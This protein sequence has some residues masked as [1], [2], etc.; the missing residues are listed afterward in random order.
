MGLPVTLV[1]QEIGTSTEGDRSLIVGFLEDNLSG[2]GRDIRIVGFEG[3]LSSSATLDELTI[4]DEEGVWF[5]LRDAELDW[6]RTALLRGRVEV[7]RITA[8]EILFERL[9]EMTDEGIDLPDPEAKPFALPELP[10][11]IDIGEIAAERVVLG[12]PVLR[13]G[14]EVT[15]SLAGSMKLADGS[16]SADL[17]ITRLDDT[18]TFDLSVSYENATEQLDLDLALSEGQGGLVTRL[19]N[20]NGAP[21]LDLDIEGTGPLD[22]FTAQIA[23]ATQGEDRLTGTVAL[24]APVDESDPDAPAPRRFSADLAGDLTPL[25][26]AEYAEF[27]GPSSTLSAQ[28]AS[29]PA[30]GFD[31]DRFTLSTQTLSLVGSAQIA[32]DGLPSAFSISGSLNGL[33]QRPVLLPFGDARS[34]VQSA[35]ILATFN[36]GESEDWAADISVEG[37][38]QD[39]LDIGRATLTGGGTIAREA[40][41]DGT[42]LLSRVNG[43]FN[44]NLTEFASDTPALQEAIGTAPAFQGDLSWREGEPLQISALSLRTDATRATLSGQLEGLDSG[45]TFSGNMSLDTP[46]LARFAG[47]SGMALEGGAVIFAEGSVSPLSGMFDLST[48]ARGQD[49]KIGIDQVDA[50]IGGESNVRLIARR[51]ETGLTVD[52]LRVSSAAVEA[53][54]STTLTSESGTVTLSARLDDLSRLGVALSGPATIDLSAE[55]QDG[56]ESWDSTLS[57][58]GPDGASADISGLLSGLE[59]VPVFD[60]TAEI[61]TPELSALSELTGMRLG[62]R[63]STRA[64][65]K[66]IPTE[67]QFDLSLTAEG[68]NLRTGIAQVD[69]VISGTSRVALSAARGADGLLQIRSAD[70]RTPAL[71]A[72]A[73]GS[74]G[75][76]ASALALTARLDDVA[77]L[78]IGLSGPLSVS[79]DLAQAG[80]GSDWATTASLTGPG[81]AT[82]QIDGQVAENFGRAN[83]TMRGSAPLGLANSFTTAALA[84]GTAAYDL[85]LNG[86]FALS[87]LSG[88]VQMQPGARVVANS[89][90]L[91][92]TLTRGTIT[93]ANEQARLDIV[94]TA[95]TGGEISTSGTLGL[96]GARVADL[97]IGLDGLVMVDPKLYRTTIDGTLQFTGPMTGGANLT[98]DVSL[99]ATEVTVSTSGLGG[100]SLPDIDHIGASSK[101]ITT[102]RRAGLLEGANGSGGGAVY[103]LDVIIRAPNQI[104]VRG[105][106]LDAEL[107]GRLRVR[108]TTADTIAVGQFSLVRGRLSLLG[109]RIDLEEG[110]IT[111]QGELDPRLRLVGVSSTDDL[112]I[113]VLLSGPL[114]DL[115]LSLT[116]SPSLPQDEVLAQLL[117]G[118]DIT[119]ISAFQAAQMAAAVATLTGNGGGLVNSIR[120][121]FGLDDL[122]LQTTENG[123]AALKLG[124]YI[125]DKVYTD[126]T[127]DSEGETE[128]N[129]NLDATRNITIKGSVTSAGDTG[130]GVFFEKDY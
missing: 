106:G 18:G 104:F 61:T 90:G 67:G 30:G 9:P 6:N 64:T 23:L 1:A 101:V 28:G 58:T 57:M 79:A 74:Y 53:D 108:G 36:A 17:D 93:L 99:G 32:A 128:I 84:Q 91:A 100:G 126:V 55:R 116:S 21:S 70:V 20:I 3:L 129:L 14:E 73:T 87:S 27:F 4:A 83:V 2:A 41:E 45:L 112:S 109:K 59:D 119:E 29:Y 12:A 63:L 125:S 38:S 88:T 78:G 80:T 68:S 124:K 52:R 113:Q 110:A 92:M 105:R 49:L 85:A 123:D 35:E 44:L 94:A 11:S 48:T 15:L 16:G 117:F 71:T 51:D 54:A 13:V 121:S 77:R 33:D 37:Y 19:A 76:E 46:R 5:T 96:S 8:G 40:T 97:A 81:G 89:A 130:V 42:T 7:T 50:L 120:D 122:D 107:G 34:L 26:T 103:G 102:Q 66:V 24:T 56:Q 22:D 82:A 127:I 31:L 98:G 118:K 65:G 115:E 72:T 62:G 39:G 60:G 95:D 25:F 111:L 47:L 75:A 114:S 43:A 69:N 86:P 10:V